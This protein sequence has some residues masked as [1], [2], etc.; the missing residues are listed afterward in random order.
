[1]KSLLPLKSF[2]TQFLLPTVDI[3]AILAW[4]LLML[5]YSFSGELRLLVHPNYFGLVTMT[6][7]VLV[8]LSV[9]RGGQ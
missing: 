3:L 8:G 5:R 7:V 9:I 2:T 6:G 4:G 1:M